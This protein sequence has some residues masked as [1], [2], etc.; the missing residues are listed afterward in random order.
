MTIRML[1]AW[2]G[3]PEQAIVSL[4]ASEETRLV[5]IGLASF[6]LDGAADGESLAKVKYNPL[7]GGIEISSVNIGG[8]SEYSWWQFPMKQAGSV[9][10]LPKDYSDAGRTGQHG[11]N[12][13][14]P[15][16]TGGYIR[17]Y[18]GF[19]L[20]S[21]LPASGISLLTDS[22]GY[23]MTINA[24]TLAGTGADVFAGNTDLTA[25]KPGLY[26]NIAQAGH[27][28]AGKLGVRAF[29][30][31]VNTLSGTFSS[32]VIGDNTDHCIAQWWDATTNTI[33]LQVDGVLVFTLENA[34]MPN[35]T[36]VLV[37]EFALGGALSGNAIAAKFFGVQHL[38]FP[39]AGL[40]VNFLDLGKIA[41]SK[42]RTGIS[43]SDPV[44]F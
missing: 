21:Y 26:F 12:Q 24:A 5:G 39:G 8:P 35:N 44:F 36:D 23:I 16:A 20:N 7:T 1:K 29:T 41:N 18:A 32:A 33:Y 3:K 37:G 27:A 40:P 6:D 42:R 25:A 43:K 2:N 34:I 31:G 11:A 13:S 14:A 9:A 19:G 28:Q 30:N 17:T 38:V 15:W 22:F 10:V 4:S